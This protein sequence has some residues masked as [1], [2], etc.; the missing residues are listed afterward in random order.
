MSIETLKTAS[1]LLEV[2]VSVM[3]IDL[4]LDEETLMDLGTSAT[5]IK[6]HFSKKGFQVSLVV[7]VWLIA[8]S[9]YCLK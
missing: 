8:S 1:I 7:L 6:R 4:A 5:T 3:R 2:Q 9:R